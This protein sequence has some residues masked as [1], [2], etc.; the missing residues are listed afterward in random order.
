ME[1]RPEARLSSIVI[2]TNVWL[3]YYLGFRAGHRDAVELLDTANELGIAML[4]AVTATKD[5]FYLIA[6]DFKHEYRRC[7]GG[8]LTPEGAAS[9]NEVAWA[10]L[11]NLEEI[12]TAVGCDQSDVWLARAQRSLHG[13]YEDNLVIAAA[14]RADADLLVTNDK[15]LVSHSPMAAL[16]CEDAL[17]Y[18]K[19]LRD[20]GE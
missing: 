6:A 9:A 20:V 4:C 8:S 5:L 7:H 3:D 10:C 15:E 16:I 13:D 1:G 12:A 14:Q 11:R 18:L 17:A 19:A 2:D